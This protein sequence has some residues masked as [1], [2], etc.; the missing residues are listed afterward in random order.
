[1]YCFKDLSASRKLCK[2][3]CFNDY[4]LDMIVQPYPY[5]KP[6]AVKPDYRQLRSIR[7][8]HKSSQSAQLAGSH[9]LSKL[10]GKKLKTTTK[11]TLKATNY[12]QVFLILILFNYS[13]QAD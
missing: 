13:N 4:S 12:F 11:V 6:I 1:M 2:I 7:D 8:K 9:P 5:I 10:W 3:I